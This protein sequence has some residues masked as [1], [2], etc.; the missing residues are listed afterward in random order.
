MIDY[1]AMAARART[2]LLTLVAGATALSM[3]WCAGSAKADEIVHFD[4]AT[5]PLSTFQVE[6]ARRAG[7]KPVLPGA[8]RLSGRLSKPG[9][10]GPFPAIVLLH[11][12][13]GIWRWDDE[14]SAKL[15]NRGYVVLGVDSLG[16]R[17]KGSICDNPGSVP[18]MTRALDAHGAKSFLGHLPFVDPDRIAVM[19]MS[20]GG[21]AALYAIERPLA[22]ALRLKPFRAAVALYPWCWEPEELDA[23]LLI[24]VGD[25][26]DWSP[27]TRCRKFASGARSASE[28]ALKEY[29]GV[30]H[31]F[32]LKGVHEQQEGHVLRYDP[33]AADDA[34]GRIEAF[35]AKHFQ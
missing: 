34:V 16:P 6:Q 13:G 3:V 5:F 4:S 35:L 11:G 24:L 32:D 15:T 2:N 9:G 19:G 30:Y 33:L 18:G 7:A 1:Q 31:L 21:E 22:S 26:D 25:L 14:W 23:P 28:I 20:H 12:C 17:G 27:A 29:P 8:Q 10:D